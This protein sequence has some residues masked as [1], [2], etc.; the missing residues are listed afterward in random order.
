MTIRQKLFLILGI[1]QVFLLV[2]LFGA[3]SILIEAIKSEPQNKRAKDLAVSFTRE[4]KERE[5]FL[6]SIIREILHNPS[7]LELLTKGLKDRNILRQNFDKFHRYMK[8]YDLNIF[9]IGSSEGKVQFRFHRVNDYGDSKADQKIIQRA[10]AGE[11]SSTLEVGH[12]GL[13]L[14]VTSPLADGT[15]LVGQVVN[16]KF[17]TSIIGNKDI[18]IALLQGSSPIVFSDEIIKRYTEKIQNLEQ[19]LDGE[20]ILFEERYYYAVVMPYQ[21]WGLSNHKLDFLIM[22]DE[23]ELK[24]AT[25]TIWRIFYVIAFFIFT[26]VFF[27]SYFF[28]KNIIYAIKNLNHAMKDLNLADESKIDTRRKDEIGEMGKVFLNMKEQILKYQNH[29]EHLVEEKT[30]ELKQSLEE[31]QRLKELQDGDYFLTSL[32]IKPLSKGSLE[33]EKVKIET[34]IRQKKTFIF[35]NRKAEIGGD[36]CV[37]DSIKLRNKNYCVFLNADAMGKSIQGAGGVLVLGTVFKSILTRTHE[38][39]HD[40]VKSPER[41]L[42][43][44]FKELQNIFVSFDG[45]MIISAIMGLLDEETGT[46]YYVN[47]EHPWAVLYRD[48]KAEFI[49]TELS[50]H[51]I[52][53]TGLNK[54]LR[55]SVFPLQPGDSIILG[56]DGRDDILKKSEEG[57]I[58]NEDETEFLKRVE[59]ADG[60]LLKIEERLKEIGELT[61]DLTLMKITF[62]SSQ[63]IQP[64]KSNLEVNNKYKVAK[65]LIKNGN[66]D[67]ALK[68][69]EHILERDLEN[70]EVQKILIRLYLKKKQYKTA[71]ILCREYL[72]K[73]PADS[74]YFY[75]LSYSL[76][77]LGEYEDAIEYGERYRAREPNDIKN[78]LNLAECYLLVLNHKRAEYILLKAEDLEPGNENLQKLKNFLIKQQ[79]KTYSYVST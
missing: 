79:T 44:C 9:E 29:L 8:D 48:G 46:L 63:K 27:L 36:L 74:K 73:R 51:K 35:R 38:S 47:A 72:D 67:E 52:G 33:T 68:V 15:L 11:I 12:S 57:P 20:R 17:L 39:P 45:T 34:L 53:L 26:A 76:K 16:E 37:A 31:I 58:M 77:H 43:D 50:L 19:Y 4:L 18:K 10:L 62:K 40:Y 1:S 56:S 54:K 61:D 60:D 23:T 24:S 32:L 42:K 7:N 49:E 66:L 22:I 64:N 3:F 5:E 28:S 30:K 21:S 59:E 78:L 71:S 41:W 2:A 14:R 6:K 75:F 55:I 70:L 65:N 13:G 69:Y 25:D